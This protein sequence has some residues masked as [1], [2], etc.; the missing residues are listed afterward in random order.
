MFK[1]AS[2]KSRVLGPITR[3]A[4]RPD[5]CLARW[6]GPWRGKY[7]SD[8]GRAAV[9]LGHK[10]VSETAAMFLDYITPIIASL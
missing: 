5:F 9:K 8:Y 2:G 1:S 4:H 7:A 6:V 10:T 3:G